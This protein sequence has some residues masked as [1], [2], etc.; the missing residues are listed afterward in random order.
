MAHGASGRSLLY[1]ADLGGR[2]IYIFTY[3]EGKAAG[4]ITGVAPVGLCSDAK[5][6]V[7]AAYFEQSKILE[8]AHGGTQ[9]I[10]TLTLPGYEFAVSC[11]VD[12]KTGNLAATTD[13][14]DLAVFKDAR[15]TP[16]YYYLS[17]VNNLY[18]C[19]YD[20]SGNLFADGDDVNSAFQLVELPKGSST[21][22]LVNVNAEISTGL[23]IMWDGSYLTLESTQTFHDS[24]LV[25]LKVA[26]S[27]AKV[28]GSTK[29]LGPPDEYPAEYWI[30][31][32]RV[33]QPEGGNTTVGLWSYPTG[34]EPT[35]SLQSVGSDL[36]GVTVSLEGKNARRAV[37]PTTAQ[38]PA[39]RTAHA[40]DFLYASSLL[41]ELYVY[42]YP[43]GKAVGSVPLST[44]ST[45]LCSDRRGNV[46][47]TSF[48]GGTITIFPRLGVF[49]IAI[50]NAAEDG[51]NGCA[52]N[53]KTGDLAVAGQGG[54]V[55]VYPRGRGTPA[56]YSLSPITNFYFCTYDDNGNLFADGEVGEFGSGG[57]GLAELPVGSQTMKA[58]SVDATVALQNALQWSGK[59]LVLQSSGASGSATFL[60]VKVSG[61]QG[62][63]V[64]TTTLT[65][66]ANEFPP[67]FLLHGSAL[68][69]PDDG[70]ADIGF[71][72][73]PAGG[74]PL[75]TLSTG[76]SDLFGVTLIR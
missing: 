61:S 64:S 39:P 66:P 36:R 16:T 28:V 46:Y 31:D 59:N 14:G 49:P 47:V 32:G 25:R 26:R 71:W 42:S 48:V 18:Y 7:F 5:G 9:P 60:G 73:Y 15:G 74:S 30:Q 2:A 13:N 76:E 21:L 19:T 62:T 40:R 58:I 52:V 4:E 51:P 11:A 69:E 68:L 57:F 17:G 20:G 10:A 33:V 75:K 27:S 41:A 8:F 37:A 29:L 65:A 34:G 54:Y 6:D 67:Q 50:L 1:V 22:Q 56:S 38:P 12:P 72:K 23:G 53:P 3:P 70:N 44:A 35:A 24:E 63:V 43:Q 45:G 55:L